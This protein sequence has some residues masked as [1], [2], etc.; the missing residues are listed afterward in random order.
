MESEQLRS[1][2]AQVTDYCCERDVNPQLPLISD[3]YFQ[4]S[5]PGQ[6]QLIFFWC[7]EGGVHGLPGVDQLDNHAL[8]PFTMFVPFSS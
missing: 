2:I 7:T 3:C 1:K 8:F 4:A 5:G 6:Y